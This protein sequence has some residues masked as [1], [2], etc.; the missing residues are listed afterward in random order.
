MQQL[1]H[2]LQASPATRLTVD[3]SCFQKEKKAWPKLKTTLEFP[4][5]S[6]V[7][8]KIHNAMDNS[9]AKVIFTL[10]LIFTIDSSFKGEDMC[11]KAIPN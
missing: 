9:S 5:I 1:E 7:K 4:V 11:A 10:P 8:E 3:I 6:L 2:C